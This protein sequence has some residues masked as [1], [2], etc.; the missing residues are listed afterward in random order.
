MA[1]VE[2]EIIQG[3]IGRPSAFSELRE[4]F[5]QT[6]RMFGTGTAGEKARTMLEQKER[7]GFRAQDGSLCGKEGVATLDFD[8][9]G[10]L[11]QLAVCGQE[12]MDM[13]QMQIQQDLMREKKTTFFGMNGFGRA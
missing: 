13:M 9:I 11:E 5:L 1:F 2:R 12:H 6:G 7:C 8:I 3:V 10:Q 4:I